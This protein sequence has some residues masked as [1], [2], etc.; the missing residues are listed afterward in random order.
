M[1]VFPQRSLFSQTHVKMILNTQVEKC[2]LVFNI[3]CNFSCENDLLVSLNALLGKLAHNPPVCS[4]YIK[5]SP[6]LLEPDL[7]NNFKKTKGRC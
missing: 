7:S 5:L 3:S 2:Y 6:A 4:I 1:C